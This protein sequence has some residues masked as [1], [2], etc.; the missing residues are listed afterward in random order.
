MH[1]LDHHGVYGMIFAC[2]YN[3]GFPSL[4][5][6]EQE[7]LDTVN[8]Y[9]ETFHKKTGIASRLDKLQMKNILPAGTAECAA[10]G[11]PTIKAASTRQVMPF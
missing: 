3:G 5:T 1:C 7:R 2:S 6:T 9:I 8:K 10:L 11:G 4:C